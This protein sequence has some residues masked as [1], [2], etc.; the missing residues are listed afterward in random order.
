MWS[1]LVILIASWKTRL[2][3]LNEIC[4]SNLKNVSFSVFESLLSRMVMPIYCYDCQGWFWLEY[5]LD[6]WIARYF[7][8]SPRPLPSHP[9]RQF[10]LPNI[11][12]RPTANS[13]TFRLPPQGSHKP[14]VVPGILAPQRVLRTVVATLSR[15]GYMYWISLKQRLHKDHPRM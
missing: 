3:N 13:G 12:T 14:Q 7:Y 10:V 15:V 6:Y 1:D 8:F 2:R 9:C 4:S 5:W 11:V